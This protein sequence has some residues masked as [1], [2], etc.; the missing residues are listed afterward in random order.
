MYIKLDYFDIPAFDLEGKATEIS[1]YIL[2]FPEEK[3]DQ[4]Q[5]TN[6]QIIVSW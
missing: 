1:K 5:S 3:Y 4:V 2:L 6:Y